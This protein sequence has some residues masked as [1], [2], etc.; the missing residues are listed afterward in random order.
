MIRVGGWGV[1][2]LTYIILLGDPAFR[3]MADIGTREASLAEE[4]G[5]P[6]DPRMMIK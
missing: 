4:S 2:L 1:Q 3:Y 6:G 5:H